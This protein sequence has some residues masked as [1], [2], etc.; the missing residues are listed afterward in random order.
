MK[1]KHFAVSISFPSNIWDNL[2]K[3]R[4]EK[5]AENFF[6]WIIFD[7]CCYG[8]IHDFFNIKIFPFWKCYSISF[9]FCASKTQTTKGKILEA[10]HKPHYSNQ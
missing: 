4:V 7:V 8:V 6:N 1:K 10:W 5:K 3:N 9:H 2:K